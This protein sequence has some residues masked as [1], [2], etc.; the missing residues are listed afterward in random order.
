MAQFP[1]IAPISARTTFE[2][3]ATPRGEVLVP[4]RKL[5]EWQIG[6]NGQREFRCVRISEH[7]FRGNG[8]TDWGAGTR[9]QYGDD[10]SVEWPEWPA[11]APVNI[12]PK[13]SSGHALITNWE[14]YPKC[15]GEQFL[16]MDDA[17]WARHFRDTNECFAPRGHGLPEDYLEFWL[18]TYEQG[19]M[20]DEV[21]NAA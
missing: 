4:L 14:L 3:Q 19:E 13:D 6:P 7:H 20:W 1:L 15:E 9:D 8:S 16:A 10:C 5:Y 2:R 12:D 21:T 18:G 11:P 17:T